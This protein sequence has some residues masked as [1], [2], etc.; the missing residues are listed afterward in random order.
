MDMSFLSKFVPALIAGAAI[1]V[2]IGYKVLTHAPADNIV[3][4]IAQ[5]VVKYETG[6][7]MDLTK[8]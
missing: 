2:A 6:V 4:E 5:Q 1:S 8:V 3:E 7:D